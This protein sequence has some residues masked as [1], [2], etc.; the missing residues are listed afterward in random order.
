MCSHGDKKTSRV[1]YIRLRSRVARKIASSR[2]LPPPPP[3]RTTFALSMIVVRT[4]R[5]S[6]QDW[7]RTRHNNNNNN[8]SVFVAV[9]LTLVL[10]TPLLGPVP[11]TSLDTTRSCSWFDK[12]T[13]KIHHQ[14]VPKHLTSFFSHPRQ[15]AGRKRLHHRKN[16]VLSQADQWS[17]F[18]VSAPSTGGLSTLLL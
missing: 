13:F 11:Q 3:S 18:S 14:L 1:G 10:L 9:I 15:C 4:A 12:K 8:T 17:Q 16:T 2:P 6:Q 7:R 5:R